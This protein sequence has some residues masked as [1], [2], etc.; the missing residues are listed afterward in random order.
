[1]TK[2]GE[3]EAEITE[4]EREFHPLHP[5]GADYN[6][7][8]VKPEQADRFNAGKPQLSYMMEA[9]VAMKGMCEVFSFGAIKYARGNWKKGLPEMEVIDSLLRHMMAY[10]NGEVLDPESGKPHVDHITCNAV[11][12]A[13]FGKRTEDGQ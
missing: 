6:K 11:F 5:L 12:L 2:K 7:P 10:A 13:T 3:I 4:K 1:M 9:D 8:T